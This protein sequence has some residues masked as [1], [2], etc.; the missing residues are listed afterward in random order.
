MSHHGYAVSAS[1]TSREKREKA[2]GVK[3]HPSDLSDLLD[4][5]TLRP[6]RQL[7][8]VPRETETEVPAG[9]IAHEDDVLR[10]ERRSAWGLGARVRAYGGLEAEFSREVEVSRERVQQASG[11]G[12]VDC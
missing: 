10:Q 11:E 3:D 9:G 6:F 2:H 12:C 1:K 8:E 7:T 4:F 5:F